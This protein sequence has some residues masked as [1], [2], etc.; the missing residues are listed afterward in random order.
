LVLD[1]FRVDHSHRGL[2]DFYL[3]HLVEMMNHRA[4]VNLRDGDLN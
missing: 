2:R 3:T 4:L 1:E